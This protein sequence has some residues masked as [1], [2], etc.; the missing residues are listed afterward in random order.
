MAK[1]IVTEVGPRVVW[2]SEGGRAQV[3]RHGPKDYEAKLDGR[4]CGFFQYSFQAEHELGVLL[5]QEAEALALADEQAEVV[6]LAGDLL[7]E[8]RAAGCN[9]YDGT[10]ALADARSRL[11]ELAGVATEWDAVARF[12]RDALAARIGRAQAAGMARALAA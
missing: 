12:E 5:H 4:S 10:V 11:G 3:L 1:R 2:Q 6:A 8:A 7:S 9:W